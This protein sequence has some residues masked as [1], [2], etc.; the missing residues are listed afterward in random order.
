MATYQDIYNLRHSTT[1]K[2]RVTVAVVSAARAVFQ[3]SGATTN[4]AARLAWA[5]QA[6]KDAE[7]EAERLMWG[8]VSHPTVQS[9]GEAVT[10][11]QLQT[12]V[13]NLVDVFAV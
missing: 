9:S 6:V 10:D 8:V 11:T 13:D 4:H 12:M 1:L 5:K 7:G 2:A 3:E